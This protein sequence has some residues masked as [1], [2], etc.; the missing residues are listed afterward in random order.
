MKNQSDY[1]GEFHFQHL[2]TKEH[3][4]KSYMFWRITS[5]IN[6]SNLLY[7]NSFLLQIILG[8]GM[9]LASISGIFKHV[10]LSVIMSIF[11]SITSMVGIYCLYHVIQSSDAKKDL[12]KQAI[13]R[14]VTFKN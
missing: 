14:V 4:H 2:S 9:V 13:H 5:R 10:Y 8:L 3:E 7:F 1:N 6:R 12:I 11:G